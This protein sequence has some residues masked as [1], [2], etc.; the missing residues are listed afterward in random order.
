MTMNAK[1]HALG[2]KTRWDVIGHDTMDAIEGATGAVNRA[3]QD[4]VTEFAWGEIFNRPGLPKKTR[5]LLNLAMLTVLGEREVLR[6]HVRGALRL[7][8]TRT[9]IREAL[10][11]AS[12]FAGFNKVSL[13]TNAAHEVFAEAD[14]AQSQSKPKTRTKTKTKTKARPRRK[15]E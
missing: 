11:Q 14:A 13:A 8:C 7:G 6:H 1:T 15:T 4:Y 5:I 9:A 3:Q 2:R 10:L 12:T